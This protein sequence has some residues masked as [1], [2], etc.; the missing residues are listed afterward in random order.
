MQDPD[1]LIQR[2]RKRA[3]REREARKRA[4]QLLEE[5]SN[6]FYAL[7]QK[8]QHLSATLEMAYNEA[9]RAN[10]VKSE[11]MAT[12]S[13]ELRTPLN[14]IIGMASLLE[15]TDLDEEQ[16]DCLNTIKESGE[17][18][19]K[20]VNDILDFSH[21]EAGTIKIDAKTFNLYQSIQKL[22]DVY[23]SQ[24]THKELEFIYTIATD[25]PEYIYGDQ[26]RFTQILDNLLSNAVKF[27][28]QGKITLTVQTEYMAEDYRRLEIN[29]QDTGIGIPEDKMDGLFDLFTQVDASHTRK[30]GGTGLG[31]A[32]TKRLAEL[33]GGVIQVTSALDK[34]SSFQLS[35][36][37]YTATEST[38][39]LPSPPS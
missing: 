23:S 3:E 28:H 10:E 24:A 5:K 8:L 26:N 14:G 27:S 13:H 32:I 31:L 22:V 25:V 29:V 12:M 36:I 39:H 15:Y 18:L 38:Q 30:Y 19:L 33:M 11:F 4:E 7:N 21:I 9:L 1:A 16:W 20:I 37:V 6:E 17:S 35:L 2:L 34:G